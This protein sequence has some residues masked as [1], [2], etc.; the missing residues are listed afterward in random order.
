MYNVHFPFVY[1][2]IDISI[3]VTQ[4]IA[5]NE[6]VSIFD[7][8]IVFKN[9]RLMIVSYYMGLEWILVGNT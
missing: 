8:I 6:I 1:I 7:R 3:V 9:E 2:Y 5:G 4:H